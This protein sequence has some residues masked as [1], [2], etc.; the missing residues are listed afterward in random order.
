VAYGDEATPGRTTVDLGTIRGISEGIVSR[1][2]FTIPGATC[3]LAL[4]RAPRRDSPDDSSRT[5]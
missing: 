1:G 4:V 5:R 2:S 3:A